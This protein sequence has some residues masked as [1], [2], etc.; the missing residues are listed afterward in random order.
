MDALKLFRNEA[1][2]LGLSLKCSRWTPS[3]SNW[4]YKGSHMEK[5]L[6]LTCWQDLK[7]GE[8]ID[9]GCS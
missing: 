3:D 7:F 8:V 6:K 2:V 5:M 9:I 4:L 1:K